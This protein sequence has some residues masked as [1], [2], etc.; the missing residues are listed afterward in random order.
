MV[1]CLLSNEP[2]LP[3]VHCA[4]TDSETCGTALESTAY[5]KVTELEPPAGMLLP[6]TQFISL[7][8]EVERSLQT[9]PAPVAETKVRPS[10][11]MSSINTPPP[12]RSPVFATVTV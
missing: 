6:S 4:E 8:L 1:D 9:H 7:L 10:P 2:N 5:V 12:V 11:T 3:S